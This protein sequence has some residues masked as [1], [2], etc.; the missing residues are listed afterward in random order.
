MEA[1]ASA[2]AD[3]PEEQPAQRK[4]PQ[5]RAPAEKADRGV[6]A[7][8]A[9]LKPLDTE[10][11]PPP[12]AAS[13]AEEQALSAG[14]VKPE[15]PAKVSRIRRALRLCFSVHASGEQRYVL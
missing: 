3:L 6:S 2:V 5:K 15:T 12:E 13:P 14:A 8:K 11:I 1:A 10:D 4:Q 7:K 9:P